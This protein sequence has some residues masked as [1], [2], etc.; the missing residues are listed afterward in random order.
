[1][2]RN[3]HM[4]IFLAV[5]L[6]LGNSAAHSSQSLTLSLD[7]PALDESSATSQRP[8]GK[9]TPTQTPVIVGRVG[10]V[11]VS[12]AFIYKSRSAASRR[13]CTLKTGA[14]LAVVKEKGQWYGVLMTNGAVGWIPRKNVEM[15]NYKL[16]RPKPQLKRTSLTSRG[17]H[18]TRDLTGGSEVVRT[19][20]TYSN[21]RYV[22]GGTNPAVG[23]DCS[24]FVRTVFARHG[25]SLPRT[26]REQARVGTRVPPD[27]LQPG[28]RLYFACHNPYIDHCGIYA[29]NGLF[30][31]CSSSRG[32]VGIDSLASDFYW[33]SLVTVRRS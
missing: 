22:Y 21:V 7:A 15:T 20:L 1:M 9:E 26:S 33:R 24:A 5:A 28:D 4:A 18:S 27:Q 8:A 10:K 31:H 32:G 14:P 16:V 29:G 3:L 13:Y 19:A 30:V 12:T 25:I 2:I 11:K 6:L 23:M 17:G